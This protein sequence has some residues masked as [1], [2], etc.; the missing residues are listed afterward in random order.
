MMLFDSEWNN[1][2]IRDVKQQ[3]FQSLGVRLSNYGTGSKSFWTIFK[4]LV[5]K[6]KYTNIPPR[7]ERNNVI[8]DFQQRSNIF[9]DLFPQQCKLTYTSGTLSPLQNFNIYEEKFLKPYW[10]WIRKK[11]MD[12]MELP[13]NCSGSVPPLYTPILYHH[14]VK[15]SVSYF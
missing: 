15:A 5:N 10:A 9:N 12:M 6:K 4:R 14:C 2:L 11:R 8:S 13:S 3:Y 7:V 1:R